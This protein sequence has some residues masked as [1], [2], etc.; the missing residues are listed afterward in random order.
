MTSRNVI[1]EWYETASRHAGG[2][3]RYLRGQGFKVSVEGMGFQVTNVGRVKMT[4][5]TIE[6]DGDPERVPLCGVELVRGV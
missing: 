3:A 5:V 1:Q 4:L 2:R 6:H